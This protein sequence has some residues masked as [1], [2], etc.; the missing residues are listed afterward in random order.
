MDLHWYHQIVSF[1]NRI[2]LIGSQCV[3]KQSQN[4]ACEKQRVFPTQLAW[5]WS[6]NL[7]KMLW[8]RF[9]KCLGTFTILLVEWLSETGLFRRLSFHV[10][11]VRNSGNTK[12]MRV[13]FFFWKYSKFIVYFKYGAKNSEKLFC[14]WYNCIWIGIVKL[15]LLTRG[16]FSSAVN[17]LTSSTK[18][19]HGKS[20]DFSQ[21]YWLGSD[22]WIW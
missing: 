18:I 16:Y 15:C 7:I 12:S 5:Q 11:G 14:F 20:R 3:N 2:I 17:V 13:I 6:M 10:F 1:K 8:W 21:L 22:Q 19:G 9:V 4:L